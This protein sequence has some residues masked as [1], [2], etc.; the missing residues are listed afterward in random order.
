MILVWF[1]TSEQYVCCHVDKTE[2]ILSWSAFSLQSVHTSTVCLN[3]PKLFDHRTNWPIG[4]TFGGEC[5]CG[6]GLQ[7][8][9]LISLCEIKQWIWKQMKYSS[10]RWSTPVLCLPFT[11]HCGCYCQSCYLAEEVDSHHKTHFPNG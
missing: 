7:G 8:R 3:G 9:C 5:V 2:Q 4:E 1:G 11:H 6:V 10:I